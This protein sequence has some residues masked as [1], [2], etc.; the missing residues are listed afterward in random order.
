MGEKLSDIEIMM[1]KFNA[2]KEKGIDQ[3]RTGGNTTNYSKIN[4]TQTEDVHKIGK[5][6][7]NLKADIDERNSQTTIKQYKTIPVYNSCVISEAN[8]TLTNTTNLNN[9]IE[10]DKEGINDLRS[11]ESVGTS[12]QPEN[13]RMGKDSNNNLN[14][15]IQTIKNNGLKI[16]LR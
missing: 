8:G 7:N 10:T 16:N 4:E 3:L 14:E 5:L 13:T 1:S 11:L 9:K 12:I 2:E 6:I 15:L